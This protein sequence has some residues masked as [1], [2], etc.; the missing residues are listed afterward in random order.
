MNEPEKVGSFTFDQEEI[1]KLRHAQKEVI[2]KNF[3]TWRIS[4]LSRSL[5]SIGSHSSS[6]T[7][8][9][10][11]LKIDGSPI[12]KSTPRR[13][14]PAPMDRESLSKTVRKTPS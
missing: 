12:R 4:F 11:S 2:L 3:L 13:K 5:G 1:S 10:S 8:S 14:R 7:R 9:D 6:D